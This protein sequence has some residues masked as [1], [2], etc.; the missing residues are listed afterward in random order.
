MAEIFILLISIF[1]PW[2]ANYASYQIHF[3]LKPSSSEITLDL[4]E[5]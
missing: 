4:H 5:T 1:S 3:S 2:L